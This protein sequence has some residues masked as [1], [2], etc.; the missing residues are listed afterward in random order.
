MNR[1]ANRLFWK[2]HG[3]MQRKHQYEDSGMD[4]LNRVTSAES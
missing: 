4:K 1:I 3:D 2:D